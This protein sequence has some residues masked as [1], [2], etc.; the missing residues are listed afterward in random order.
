MYRLQHIDKMEDILEIMTHHI[1]DDKIERYRSSYIYRGIPNSD[2]KLKTSLERNCKEK[3]YVIEESILRNFSKY[4]I[5]DDPLIVKSIWRQMIIGQ[6]HGLLTRLMDWT[7]SPLVGLH[8]ATSEQD[9][10]QLGI[11]DCVLWE[12]NVEE[13]NSLL[14]S[15]CKD[16]LKEEKAYLFTVDMLEKVANSIA[17]YDLLLGDSAIILLEPP[18]ID[19][20]IISQ[21]S[22]FSIIPKGISDVEN[23][24]E[25]KTNCT[26][27]YIIDKKL[28]WQVKDMLDQM[29][30]NERVLFPG[31]DGVSAWLKRHYYVK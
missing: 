28:R 21:Y 23:F 16:I 20:R 10:N 13:L 29:N 14:P 27:K 25:L 7:Y 12:I 22:Y 2:Y 18:S 11:N 5:N 1:Y 8:F 6:H 17:Q 19:Q 15:K 4:A 26:T 9:V 3:G 30:I 31:L 24:L